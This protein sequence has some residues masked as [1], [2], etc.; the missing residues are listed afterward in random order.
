[1]GIKFTPVSCFSDPGNAGYCIGNLIIL[2]C[3][4]MLT[5]YSVSLLVWHL[6]AFGWRRLETYKTYPTWIFLM[7]S[8]YTIITCIR[9]MFYF[10]N[11]DYYLL[12][13]INGFT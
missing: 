8:V 5:I 1:M 10:K 13:L 9:Y 12:L 2:I 6:Q 11:G 3:S 4:A 7:L